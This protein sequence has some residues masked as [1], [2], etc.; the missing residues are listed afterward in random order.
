MYEPVY[1]RRDNRY[2]LTRP[3]DS[4]SRLLFP[5]ERGRTRST[6][7]FWYGPFQV[8]FPSGK[9]KRL[10]PYGICPPACACINEYGGQDGKAP[11]PMPASPWRGRCLRSV[12]MA[13]Y[14]RLPAAGTDSEPIATC[15]ETY[16]LQFLL[17]APLF[18]VR[19]VL[20]RNTVRSQVKTYKFHNAFPTDNI[21]PEMADDIDDRL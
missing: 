10:S 17:H 5:Y 18:F 1:C 20:E 3:T 7:C 21:A 9:D 2:D 12:S 15:E 16:F 11:C 19:H 8:M 13:S 14:G 4:L 6:P